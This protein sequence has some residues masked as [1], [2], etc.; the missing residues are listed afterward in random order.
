M[1]EGEED[2]DEFE[3]GED[4]LEEEPILILCIEVIANLQVVQRLTQLRDIFLTR[5]H[6]ISLRHALKG[7]ST[8]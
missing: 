1:Q 8:S 2:P 6:I 7:H 3:E 5:P 4:L